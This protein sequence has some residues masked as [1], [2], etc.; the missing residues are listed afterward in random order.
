MTDCARAVWGVNGT[1]WQVLTPEYGF[2]LRCEIH[3]KNFRIII[4]PIVGK[5]VEVP[6][7]KG[8][9]THVVNDLGL[10]KNWLLT[11]APLI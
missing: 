1:V 10:L 6:E 9:P 11:L 4:P 3:K 8:V 7:E 5:V 2:L